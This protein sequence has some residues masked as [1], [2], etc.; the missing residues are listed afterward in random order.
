VKTLNKNPDIFDVAIIG[1]GFSGL[2]TL[3]HLV[4]SGSGGNSFAIIEPGEHLGHGLA[5]STLNP[6]HLLNVPAR[7]MSA[8]PDQPDHFTKWLNGRWRDD[9]YV[10]RCIY[11]AYLDDIARDTF[12]LA[13]SK[14]IS[15]HHIKQKA[16][17]AERL[18]S[19]IYDLV[20][21]DSGHIRS[22][23]ILIATGNLPVQHDAR[24][25][26]DPWQYD[27]KECRDETG[28]VAII[29]TGLTMIDTVLSLRAAGFKGKIL[30]ISRRGLLPQV[31]NDT[32]AV[33]KSSLSLPADTP[34][35][36][37]A[38]MKAFRDEVKNCVVWPRVFDRWRPHLP[39]IWQKLDAKDRRRFF[40]RLFT[41]WN[42]H[43]HRMAP[44]I[45]AFIRDE[46]NAGTLKVLKGTAQRQKAAKTFDC[47]GPCYDIRSSDSQLLQNLHQ[48]G[49]I[50]PHATGW[51]LKIHDGAYQ[52][53]HDGS[54]LAIGT[55]L[56]GEHL[57]TTAIPE[58]R[59]QAQK[60]AAHLLAFLKSQPATAKRVT[61]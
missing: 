7:N 44:E 25:T 33:Y 11:A 52:A 51:G 58:L 23:T 36:P 24:I 60:V 15:L 42:V 14:G 1:G 49:L 2:L 46:M 41:L 31:H 5:Y 50:E 10:P 8:L 13:K 18:P 57:E 21:G 4:S 3:H 30:G 40:H 48:R 61:G 54:F 9:D 22:K 47:R 6:R 59:Q 53:G 19:G 26:S 27:Y 16:I 20:L 45:G 39:A 34:R 56:I 43:R 37:A 38:L 29:G 12:N 35:R 28:D 55:P 17:D 32:P